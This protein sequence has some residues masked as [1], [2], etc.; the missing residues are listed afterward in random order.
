[1]KAQKHLSVCFSVW[2]PVMGLQ[3]A[4]LMGNEEPRIW[5][6]VRANR[7]ISLILR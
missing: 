6:E 3:V 5:R 2:E 7:A 1:M 4:S